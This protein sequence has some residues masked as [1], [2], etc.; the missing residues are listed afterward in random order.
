VGALGTEAQRLTFA[1]PANSAWWRSV[2][3]KEASIL[4][5][6][7]DLA[8][9]VGDFNTSEMA[10]QKLS[11]QIADIVNRNQQVAT[12]L[13]GTLAELDKRAADLQS[14]LGEIGAPLKVV[15]FKLSEIAPLL[16]LI[17]AAA[18][19]AIAA[20]T[21]DGPRRMALAAELVSGE[22]DRTAIR[23]ASC[24]GWRIARAGR[25]DRIRGRHRFRRLGADRCPSCCGRS[26]VLPAA[27]HSRRDRR[28]GRCRG[29]SLPVAQRRPGRVRVANR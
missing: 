19:A 2:R 11:A 17:I 8:A 6:T 28:S 1:P 22:A 29:A 13:N 4:S 14:Q 7:S 3:G 5:M 23:M 21:A 24:D 10:L 15:S 12:A 27:A 16:P 20:W 25:M 9:R 26:A 18:I